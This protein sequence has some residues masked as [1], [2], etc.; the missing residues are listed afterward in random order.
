[1]SIPTAVFLDPN[2]SVGQHYYAQSTALS[3]SVH[4]DMADEAIESLQSATARRGVSSSASSK[5][6]PTLV[7]RYERRGLR[8]T[9]AG[10]TRWQGTYPDQAFVIQCLRQITGETGRLR[11]GRILLCD[12][13]P[14]WSGG[15]EQWLAT[16]GVRGIRTP[17]RAPNCNAYAERLV[18]SVKEECL[19]RLVPLGERQLR[20]TLR[21]SHQERNH[22]DAR[23]S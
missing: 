13:D 16:A 8:A 21:H 9:G 2:V 14:K 10:C 15:A 11:E 12:R 20:T 17:P 7:R 4:F 19:N 1:M 5:R 6:S 3:T 22:Q 18:R 23:T